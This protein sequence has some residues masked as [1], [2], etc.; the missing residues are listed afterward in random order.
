M[1][2]RRIRWPGRPEDSPQ[3]FSRHSGEDGAGIQSLVG[4]TVYSY[5]PTGLALGSNP[6]NYGSGYTISPNPCLT[7][8]GSTFHVVLAAITVT[9]AT[10]VVSYITRTFTVADPGVGN[11]QVYY[12]TIYD[13]GY[14]GDA[15]GTCTAYCETNQSKVGIPGYT[16]CGSIYVTHTGGGAIIVTLGGWPVSQAFLVNGV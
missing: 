5:T 16:Y 14:V 6:N 13:P 2:F 12:V 1:V 4:L 9:F 7:Q 8:P 10:N 15:G 11:T 3:H